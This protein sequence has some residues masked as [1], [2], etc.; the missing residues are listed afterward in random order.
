VG[1]V[2]ISVFGFLGDGAGR[3][4][5]DAYVEELS[6]A[7]DEGFSRVWT[8]Q[9]PYEPD[10]LVTLA[11]ALR[12]V[13][14][15]NVGT[16][17]LPIQI[18]HPMAMAQRALTVNLIS[19][20]RLT[21]GLGLSHRAVTERVWG[22]PW[23]RP[24]RRMGEYLDGL[25]PLLDGRKA[26]ATGE[27][28]TTRGSLRI[29]APR[30]DV[31]IAA[32]GPQMLRLAGRRTSGTITWMTGPRTLAEHV[33]PTLREAAEQAGRPHNPVRVVASLPVSVTDQVDSA[34]DHAAQQFAIYGRLPSYRAMLDREGH[35][36]PQDAALIGDE[37]TVTQRI[38][39]LRAAGVDEFVGLPFGHSPEDRART[40]A[41]L[42]AYASEP[43]ES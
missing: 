36:G 31:Y 35:P 22:V 5:V 9:L 3:S 6:R 11:V 40:R 33:G 13:P 21:L 37:K 2:Q 41:L 1:A 25:L 20:G 32:L 30:P 38:D 24:I 28:T 16:G 8:A 43:S 17:V 4:P 18:E 23:D 26:D 27:T 14:D 39:E 7:R 42:H 29:P 10:L 19:G 34:R 15:V 12:E